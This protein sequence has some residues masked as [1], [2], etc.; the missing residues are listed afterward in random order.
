MEE[1]KPAAPEEG[2]GG[3][4][5]KASGKQQLLLLL[6]VQVKQEC[7]CI[8]MMALAH[9]ELQ[10]VHASRGATRTRRDSHPGRRPRRERRERRRR[11]H[12]HQRP[13]HNGHGRVAP[14]RGVQR[15]HGVVDGRAREVV[16]GAKGAPIRRTELEILVQNCVRTNATMSVTEEVVSLQFRFAVKQQAAHTQHGR[17]SRRTMPFRPIQ[18]AC[19]GTGGRSGRA[20][21]PHWTD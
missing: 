2:G 10:R 16:G 20:F 5:S 4:V 12:R 8:S 19:C 17:Q 7:G 3:A 1:E 6:P 13:A 18:S 14:G 11:R 21:A 15:R 9:R